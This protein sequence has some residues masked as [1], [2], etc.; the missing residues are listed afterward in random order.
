MELYL[1]CFLGPEP[2]MMKSPPGTGISPIEPSIYIYSTTN[3]DIAF[4]E[5]TTIKLTKSRENSKTANNKVLFR[6]WASFVFCSFKPFPLWV[7]NSKIP[8]LY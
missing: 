5:I 1:S 3:L 8:S 2:K 7:E 6:L 4:F